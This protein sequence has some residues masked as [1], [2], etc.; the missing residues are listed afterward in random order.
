MTK[1]DNSDQVIKN[2]GTI[3]IEITSLEDNLRIDKFLC[4]K[5]SITFSLAQKLLREKKI[6]VNQNIIKNSIKL[7]FK[8]KIT[9]NDDIISANKARNSD[10]NGSKSLNSPAIIDLIAKIAKMTIFEDENILIINKPSSLAVQGGSNIKLSLDDALQFL[11]Q[12]YHLNNLKYHKLFKFYQEY[13]H[14][15]EK[16][17]INKLIKMQLVHRLDRDTTGLLI[18]AKNNQIAQFLTAGFRDKNISKIYQ[19]AILGIPKK[20]NG[21]I[22]IPLSKKVINNIEKVYKDREGKEAIS[23][24]QVIA[25]RGNYSLLELSPITGRT[26][27]LRVHCKEIGYPI[28]NDIKYGGSVVINRNIGKKMC[29]NAYKITIN[30]YYGKDKNLEIVNPYLPDFVKYFKL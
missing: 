17:N 23:G 8:D 22:N 1:K 15:L 9:I 26:H 27:Q 21:T 20:L 18:I 11:N 6:T 13:S 12:Q 24:F 25:S 14:L 5:F 28:V 29:L 2:P 19:A 30:D 16:N 3:D 4:K 10:N 7:R